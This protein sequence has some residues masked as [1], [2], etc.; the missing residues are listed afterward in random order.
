VNALAPILVSVLLLGVPAYGAGSFR[1]DTE[2][3]PI[4]D[5]HP[6]VRD[7]LFSRFAIASSGWACRIGNIVSPQFGGRRVGPYKVKAKARGTGGEY[8]HL[9]TI[10]T[11]YIVK[12]AEGNDTEWADAVTISEELDFVEVTPLSSTCV[13]PNQ[14]VVQPH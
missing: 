12:D 10:Y 1:L 2:L 9:I 11:E 4:L 8:T 3:A 5:Q 6:S 7:F 14:S 13:A